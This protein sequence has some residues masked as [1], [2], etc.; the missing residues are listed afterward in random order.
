M[1]HHLTLISSNKKTGPIPVSTHSRD[2]CPTSCKMRDAGCYAELGP[3]A[4]HWKKVTEGLRGG[5]FKDF[6]NQIKQLPKKAIWRY[7]QAGDLPG[8]G[9]EI[10]RAELLALAKANR[11]R[12]V[13]AFT[14]KP[15]TPKNLEAIQQAEQF[16]FHINASA[17][18]LAEADDLISKGVSV[19]T[20]LPSY[21]GRKKAETLHAYRQR[22]NN[23]PRTTPSGTILSVCP[24]TYTDT[25]CQLC[26]VCSKRRARGVVIGFPAHGSKTR[27][28]DARLE[29]LNPQGQPHATRPPSNPRHPSPHEG[30]LIGA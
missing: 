5:G 28:V 27:V 24:A 29:T 1:Q 14:H 16:G 23:L 22:L 30:A 19:V 8:E 2:S 11:G 7:A 18:S 26:G 6:L 13:I 12:R 15:L 9:D 25:T 20:V 21:Y 4:I 17:D 3:M 10:D